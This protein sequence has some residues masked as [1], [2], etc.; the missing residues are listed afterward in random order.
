ML[1]KPEKK[2]AVI[3]LSVAVIL[4]LFYLGSVYLFPNLGVSAYSENSPD[5]SKVYL[6]GELISYK[7]TTT[8]GHIL[9]NV[10]GATVFVENGAESLRWKAGDRL[11]ITGTV[12]TYGSTKEIAAKPSDISIL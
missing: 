6:D 7:I 1:T 10:S 2:A 5:G 4:I 9:M 11:H 8:G 12:Q 3:L